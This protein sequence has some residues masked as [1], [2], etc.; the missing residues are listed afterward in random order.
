MVIKGYVT[1]VV[2]QIWINNRKHSLNANKFW[3]GYVSLLFHRQLGSFY[4]IFWV[5]YNWV[6]FNWH[7]HPP[8]RSILYPNGCRSL[9]LATHHCTCISFGSW[10]NLTFA[11]LLW[12][13][14]CQRS[15]YSAE[16]I[17]LLHCKIC[18]V[19]QDQ[20]HHKRTQQWC[21]GSWQSFD[22]DRHKVGLNWTEVAYISWGG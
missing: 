13:G 17:E 1:G 16:L 19:A 22:A 20:M 11:K 15:S 4:F 18:V 21:G 9:L 10:T 3:L 12:M 8:S 6:P 14:Q 5:A 2:G 7:T